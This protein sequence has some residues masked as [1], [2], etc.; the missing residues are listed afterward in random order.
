MKMQEKYKQLLEALLESSKE[1]LNSQELGELA[2]ISQRTVIRYMKELKEQSLKYG[3]FIHTV[4][5]RG[6]RL[7]IIEE[8]KFRDALA[9]E[10]DVEVTK[11]LFKLFF[12]R[13]CKLDDLAELLHYSR[14]GMSRIIEKV[15]KKLEREGL[16]LLNKPY[17]PHFSL[18]FLVY[19]FTIYSL[20]SF[21]NRI[22]GIVF[23]FVKTS[24]IHK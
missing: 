23:I 4:K 20:S 11:V 15:E 3:F 22:F 7:E 10:E 6:Y 8:E 19:V 13:T 12:E 16:R 5:G 18:C 9:V 1:F 14:S 21:V 17:A 24:K 2:G